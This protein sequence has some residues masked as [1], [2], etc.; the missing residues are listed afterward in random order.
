MG[1]SARLYLCLSLFLLLILQLPLLLYAQNNWASSYSLS[2][3]SAH[4]GA[5]RQTS[6]GGFILTG[7][8]A[9][10]GSSMDVWVL[11]LDSSGIIQ[12]QKSYGGS[13]QDNGF[14]IEQTSDGGYIVAGQTLSFG[15]GPNDAWILKLDQA[16]NVEWQKTLGGSGPDF[17]L[18]IKQTADDGFIVGAS[19]YPLSQPPL[20]FW[21]IKLDSAGNV[22]WQ[23]SY[24]GTGDD[25]AYS[26]SITSDGG[27]IVSG[28]SDSFGAGFYDFWLLKLDST[29]GI[30]WEKTYGGTDTDEYSAFGAQE[31]SD[32]GFIAAGTSYDRKDDSSGMV[33][34]KLDSNGQIQWQKSYGTSASEWAASI[35]QTADG[36]YMLAGQTG[37]LGTGAYWLLKLDSLGDIDWQKAYQGTYF[38]RLS[39][40]IQT[41]DGGFTVSGSD[42]TTY[43]HGG[44]WI[45]KVDD[46]GEIDPSCPF[47]ADTNVTPVIASFTEL[48]TTTSAVDT[49]ATPFSTSATANIA[50][51]S[52]SQQC[53]NT[54]IFCD[55]FGDGLLATDWTYL[56][57]SWSEAGGNLIG[58]PVNKRAIAIARPAFA[59]CDACS[60]QASVE[61]AGVTGNRVSLLT[62]YVDNKTNVEVILKEQADRV[63]IKQ[64]LNGNIV[65]KAKASVILD[66]N[67][68]YSVL[69]SYD[70]SLLMLIVDGVPVLT[71]VPEGSLPSGT[72]GFKATNTTASIGEIRVD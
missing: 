14:W 8:I 35:Q 47:I 19:T 62:H 11:K 69:L 34:L 46:E 21:L 56:K 43:N 10:P 32:D 9:V 57:P 5:I 13:Y 67:T 26:V 17:A 54:C 31:T 51:A 70:G 25:I 16:G 36:G 68:S 49:S 58:S 23:K 4:A 50:S 28:A 64:R 38:Q 52:Y 42:P 44:A 48:S 1:Y 27:F 29:G 15:T 63:V 3:A 71:L 37:P 18:S 60:I 40:V 61:S 72:V 33:V 2:N 6:D 53:V 24:G 65:A 41:S 59:G 12:W 22:I 30:Q 7:A 20:D 45:L 39:W 66:P 55:S